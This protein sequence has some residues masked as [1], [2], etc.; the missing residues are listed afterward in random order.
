MLKTSGSDLSSQNRL[1]SPKT[2]DVFVEFF[3]T[4]SARLLDLAFDLEEAVTDVFFF[5]ISSSDCFFFELNHRV[6]A[7]RKTYR[8][9][10]EGI[11]NARVSGTPRNRVRQTPTHYLVDFTAGAQQ[12]AGDSS[13]GVSNLGCI[14]SADSNSAT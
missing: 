4:V 6:L 14:V 3:A 1:P 10:I 13:V 11:L 2:S 8:H 12:T 9:P 5:G 7:T